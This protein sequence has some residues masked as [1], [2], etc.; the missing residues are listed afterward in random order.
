MGPGISWINDV[1]MRQLANYFDLFSFHM[2]ASLHECV[3]INVLYVM[4]GLHTIGIFINVLYCQMLYY[5]LRLYG[6]GA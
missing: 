3:E 2:E 1:K 6:P 5:V 4:H